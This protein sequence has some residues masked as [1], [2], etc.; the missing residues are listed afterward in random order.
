L[1]S[2]KNVTNEMIESIDREITERKNIEKKL[3][4]LIDKLQEALA[5]IKTL[6]GTKKG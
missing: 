2:L 3:E 6:N 5:R 4:K 1:E